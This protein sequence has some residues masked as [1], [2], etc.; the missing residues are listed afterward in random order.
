MTIMYRKS[1]RCGEALDNRG[2]ATHKICGATDDQAWATGCEWHHGAGHSSGRGVHLF[3]AVTPEQVAAV[4]ALAAEVKAARVAAKKRRFPSKA[5]AWRHV[6]ASRA[7][8][9]DDAGHGHIEVRSGKFG[10]F[11]SSF[12]EP[13]FRYF[14]ADAEEAN[15][16]REALKVRL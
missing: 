15:D 2:P 9:T 13:D 8:R 5:A 1:R 10:L 12:G 4:E 16:L 3:W 7:E 6:E 14:F 11:I